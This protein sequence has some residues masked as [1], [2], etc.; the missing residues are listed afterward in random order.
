LNATPHVCCVCRLEL[1]VDQSW[2]PTVLA[3]LGQLDRLKRLT[4]LKLD[5]GR[6]QPVE[7]MWEGERGR[8]VFF[9]SCAGGGGSQQG[10]GRRVGEWVCHP[11][12]GIGGQ[13]GGWAD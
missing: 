2:P 12:V 1:T 3:S 6:Q 13:D 11:L 9:A 8:E 4:V 10:L 5:C 7:E